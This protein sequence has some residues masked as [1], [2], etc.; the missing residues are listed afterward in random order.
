M[1]QQYQA[2][3]RSLA[4]AVYITR[5][6]IAYIYS[7]LSHYS[8]NP[9]PKHQDTIEYSFKYLKGTTKYSIQFGIN[10]GD[11]ETPG[12]GLDLVA[13]YN[14]SW[15]DNKDN[16]RST[17]GYI[18]KLGDSIVLQKS[19][20]QPL[21]ICSTAKAEYMALDFV[22][23]EIIT[24]YR[25]LLEL[26]RPLSQSTKVYKDNLPAIEFIKGNKINSRSK[27]INIQ[28]HAI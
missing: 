18:I 27:Y 25:L 24:L 5:A 1:K 21:V 28:W 7:Q 26:R 8:Y 16:Y 13:Y 9:G 17:N 10:A 2:I 4:F 20:K 3:Y 14:S 12:Y 11:P 22:T 6:D 19:Y 23:R 15:A